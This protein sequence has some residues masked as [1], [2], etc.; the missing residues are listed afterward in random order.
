[1]NILHVRD[2]LGPNFMR[3][4][5]KNDWERQILIQNC[6]LSVTEKKQKDKERPI[7]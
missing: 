7:L 5:K 6:T 3:E 4:K 2:P 1:M